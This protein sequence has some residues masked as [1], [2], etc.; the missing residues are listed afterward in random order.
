M[1]AVKTDI[2]PSAESSTP[3]QGSSRY[4]PRKLL[5][6]RPRFRLRDMLW[7]CL[8]CAV[9]MTWYRDRQQLLEQ[10]NRQFGNVNNSWSIDQIL[11]IPN[12]PAP[13]DRATAWASRTTNATNEWVI[14]EFPWSCNVAK[15]EIVET[16][17]PGAVVRICSVSAV[18]AET[19]LWKGK[20]PTPVTAAMGRSVIPM[21]QGTWTRRIKIYLDSAGVP[22][23]NEID[24]VAL[25]D[26]DGTIQW[27]TNAWAS[28]S[29][30]QN[31]EMPRWFWP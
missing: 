2:D 7:F 30:G 5:K 17:N 24:A 18:G 11:G 28:S 23:W 9:L 14:V 20:D 8:L 3:Q 22:G 29:F 15:V 21:P 10:L 13:G 12:T 16:Y 19:E 25:H 26:R 1:S 4:S 31:R 27:A 6:Y